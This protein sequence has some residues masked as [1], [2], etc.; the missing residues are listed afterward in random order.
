MVKLSERAALD[1]EEILDFSLTR[2][3]VDVAARYRQSLN[4]CFSHLD[5][6]PHMGR[7][8]DDLHAGLRRFEHES[9]IVFYTVIQAGI[10]IVRVLH[11]SRDVPRLFT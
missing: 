8:A 4:N 2:F 11:K 7:E 9:H 3:G 6:N 1:I 5:E 10:L